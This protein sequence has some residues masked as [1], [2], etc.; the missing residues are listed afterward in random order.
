MSYRLLKTLSGCVNNHHRMIFITL[1]LL[2]HIKLDIVCMP[3]SAITT[4]TSPQSITVTTIKASLNTSTSDPLKSATRDTSIDETVSVESLE[5]NLSSSPQDNG[6]STESHVRKVRAY[7]PPI[8]P[9]YES[10]PNGDSGTVMPTSEILDLP[11]VA[12]SSGWAGLIDVKKTTTKPMIL[13]RGNRH[14]FLDHNLIPLDKDNAIDETIVATRKTTTTATTIRPENTILDAEHAHMLMLMA[15]GV[16]PDP[17]SVSFANELQEFKVPLM[18]KTSSSRKYVSGLYNDGEDLT[19]DI[20]DKLEELVEEVMEGNTKTNEIV[21]IP[22]GLDLVP[23]PIHAR[24]QKKGEIHPYDWKNY[25]RVLEMVRNNYVQA[26]VTPDYKPPK[27]VKITKAKKK[28]SD[29]YNFT[30]SLDDTNMTPS[31]VVPVDEYE[32]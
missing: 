5:L 16:E 3:T 18:E 17:I 4:S 8:T 22:L 14:R 10:L 12:S 15:K 20:D 28:Y 27:P 25:E 1:V 6:A 21:K 23:G 30:D 19:S 24:I 9:T 26:P 32:E 2:Y 29:Y 31:D 7:L 11:D 13:Y